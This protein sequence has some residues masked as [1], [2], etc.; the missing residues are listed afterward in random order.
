LRRS[1]LAGS[2]LLTPRPV[3]VR[4]RVKI[5][6]DPI[7]KEQNENRERLR[8]AIKTENFFLNG[9]T[10]FTEVYSTVREYVYCLICLV[11]VCTLYRTHRTSTGHRLDIACGNRHAHAAWSWHMGDNPTADRRDAD[12]ARA[13]TP[14][15]TA[16]STQNAKTRVVS[17][18]QRA[19]DRIAAPHLSLT[20][21]Q[22]WYTY[23]PGPRTSRPSVGRER[24][25]GAQASAPA[26]PSQPSALCGPGTMRMSL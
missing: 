26:V 11:S 21:K 15:N 13:A 9:N 1:S 14:P 8:A 25:L 5:A 17:N 16:V 3:R 23:I 24:A 4:S 20:P 22:S 19:T 10:I 7:Q 2:A 12:P 6:D 18:E